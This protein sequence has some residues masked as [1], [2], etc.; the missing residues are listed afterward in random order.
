MTVL[1]KTQLSSDAGLPT[2]WWDASRAD[3]DATLQTYS[4][5]MMTSSRFS[6]YIYTLE[7]WSVEIPKRPDYSR[8]LQITEV[9]NGVYENRLLLR[10]R[11]H[12]SEVIH[13]ERSRKLHHAK[14]DIIPIT[15]SNY[16]TDEYAEYYKMLLDNPALYELCARC[17]T[18]RTWY[19]IAGRAQ[20][21]AT[22]AILRWL[23]RVV[24]TG[25]DNATG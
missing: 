12:R 23:Y 13:Y 9:L 24:H 6:P 15:P 20:V 5:N 16:P 2:Y 18:L 10:V 25:G 8:L 7:Q 4:R 14:T 1:Y 19:D 3:A 17:N 21:K 11:V 22:H